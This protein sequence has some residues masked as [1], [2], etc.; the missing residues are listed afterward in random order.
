NDEGPVPSLEQM[1]NAAVSPVEALRVGR[2]QSEH[3]TRKPDRAPLNRQMNMVS[4]QAEGQKAEFVAL[5]AL[6][7]PAQI[8]LP[9]LVVAED[10]FPLVPSGDDV[11]D[12]TFA[13]QP[14][15]P[16]HLGR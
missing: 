3:H 12:R 2:L 9:V 10:R 13:F 14:K 16:S 1:A 8:D 4:H 6:A 5:P 11:V 15:R 7:K